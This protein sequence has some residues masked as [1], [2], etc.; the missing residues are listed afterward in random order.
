MPKNKNKDP[1]ISVILS[2]LT[3]GLGQVYQGRF[4]VAVV[5]FVSAVVSA[6]LILFVIGIPMLIVVWIINVYDAYT[7]F[8]DDYM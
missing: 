2:M 3:A 5:L 7:R 8:L 4:L 6:F 1:V